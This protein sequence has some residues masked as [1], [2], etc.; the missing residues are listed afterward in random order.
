LVG[1]VVVAR[2]VVA[3]TSHMHWLLAVVFEVLARAAAGKEVSEVTDVL[4]GVVVPLCC[5]LAPQPSH[6]FRRP[7]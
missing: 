2:V 4:V 6:T 5:P 1:A 7:L 3:V